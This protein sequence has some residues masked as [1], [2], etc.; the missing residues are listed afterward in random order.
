M[1]THLPTLGELLQHILASTT[2]SLRIAG[3]L[4]QNC[5][6]RYRPQ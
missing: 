3:L 6:V 1:A 4:P 5:P 2:S